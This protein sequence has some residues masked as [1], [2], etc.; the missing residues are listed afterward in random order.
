MYSASSRFRLPLPLLRPP[1]VL[2]RTVSQLSGYDGPLRED[3][4]LVSRGPDVP[5]TRNAFDDCLTW[6]HV[7][8]PFIPFT[9]RWQKALNRRQRL[10]ERGERDVVIIA[11]WSTGMRNVYDAYE[12]AKRLGYQSP[13]SDPRRR[14]DTHLDEYLVAGGISTDEYRIL[15]I[16]HG[17]TSV[18]ISL[19]M[20]G[21]TGRAEVPYGLL[22]DGIGD[23][24]EEKLENEI[25]QH[26][27][28]KGQSMQLL[29]LIGCMTCAF[30]CC[31]LTRM[32]STISGER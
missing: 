9:S 2:F 24:V 21:F 16:F 5:I 17:R 31:H 4:D 20:P 11:I 15:A 6:K 7:E 18:D 32:R 13:S 19:S 30:D 29:C 28:I 26:T 27:G 10:I 8:T 25:Y 23:T 14:L 3:L 22:A 12:V 1:D